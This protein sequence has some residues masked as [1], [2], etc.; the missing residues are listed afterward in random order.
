[1]IGAA[2]GTSSCLRGAALQQ[3]GNKLVMHEL[4]LLSSILIVHLVFGWSGL[5]EVLNC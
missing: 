5:A 4:L 2:S 3:A 1:V